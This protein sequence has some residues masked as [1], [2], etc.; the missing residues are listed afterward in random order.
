MRI[1]WW[2]LALQ[3]I[4]ALVLI[5]LLSRFLFRPVANI[6]AERKA[7]ASRLLQQAEEVK[8]N[9]LKTQEAARASLAEITDGKS[10]ALAAAVADAQTQKDALLAAA[11]A[12]AERMH[13]AARAEIERETK[14]ERHAQMTHASK[15]AVDIARRLVERLPS[16]ARVGGFIDSLSETARALPPETKADFDRNGATRLKT[17]RPLTSEEQAVCHRALESAFGR[18]IAFAIE[19]DPSIIA[20]LELE[21]TH[22]SIKNSLRADLSRIS[23]ALEKHDANDAS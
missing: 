1:D 20:G 4:N 8:A 14:L 7:A 10:A 17:P 3:A 23:T 2:T 16:S 5:W 9:A 18:P 12:D 15:L 22:T 11:R 21:N 19:V 13:E 6:I